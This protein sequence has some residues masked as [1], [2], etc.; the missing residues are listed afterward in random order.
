MANVKAEVQAEVEN[1]RVFVRVR[2][3]TKKE[4]AEGHQNVLLVDPKENLI[5]LNRDGTN[6]KPFKFDQV[7]VEDST[8]VAISIFVT[9]PVQF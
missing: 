7:F 4:E 5:A 8:Q 1:V 9:R 2:P 6:P 3:L